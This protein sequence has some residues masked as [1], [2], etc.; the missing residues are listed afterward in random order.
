ME[1]ISEIERWRGARYGRYEHHPAHQTP[2]AFYDRQ[3]NGLVAAT[4]VEQ[5]R[6][7]AM[8]LSLS[9]TARWP[10][11]FVPTFDTSFR[12]ALCPNFRLKLRTCK[13]SGSVIPDVHARIRTHTCTEMFTQRYMYIRYFLIFAI[14]SNIKKKRN[15][16]SVFKMAERVIKMVGGG[17][18]D[19][20]GGRLNG[21]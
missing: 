6:S 9:D 20:D 2:S 15:N 17:M 18:G 4:P 5:F 12:S 11:F 10:K 19:K 16:V 8:R 3:W 7:R 14:N 13:L 1:T 21:W